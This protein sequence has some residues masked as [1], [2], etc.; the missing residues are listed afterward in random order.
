MVSEDKNDTCL[1]PTIETD[2]LNWLEKRT[3]P[4]F[5]LIGSPGVGKTTMA[6]R[7][8]RIA[9]SRL[10]QARRTAWKVAQPASV[11]KVHLEAK[12]TIT[13]NEA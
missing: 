4:A 9:K 7:V 11:R 10:H 3:H 1:H 13:T 2:M 6:Y 12:G 5:L 8:S